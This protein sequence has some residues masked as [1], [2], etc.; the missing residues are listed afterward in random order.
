MALAGLLVNLGLAVVKLA[1]GLVGNA[2]ALVAD[3]IESMTDIVGSVVVWGG[4]HIAARPADERHPYGYGK[5]EALAALAVTVIIAAAGLGIAFE[6]VREIV[7]PHHA[8]APF[9]LG[10]L[11]GVVVV[12]ELLFRLVLRASR[13]GDSAAL[14]ADAWHHRSDA[15]TSAAAFVGIAAALVGGP[16]YESAD[17]WAALLAAGVILYNAYRLSRQPVRELMDTA[18]SDLIDRSRA[19]A[20]TIPGVVNLDKVMA[21]K[22]GTR[23]WLDMHVRVDPAMTVRDAH[24]L[25]H[26][27]KDHL[28]ASVPG[29]Q[30]VLVHVEPA[31]P[32]GARAEVSTE[33]TPEPV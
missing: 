17:D 11:V 26:R 4:L 21:R 14:A 28:R 8:P 6:A 20:A 18:P 9:T 23:Y 22:S 30:D 3:A 15:I 29:I 32:D 19:A 24:S 2:Y 12:K 5:A 33:A 25:A 13:D 10:V 31:G 1:A 7:T 16:G 27:V